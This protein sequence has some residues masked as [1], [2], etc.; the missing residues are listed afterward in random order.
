MFKKINFCTCLQILKLLQ[1]ELLLGIERYTVEKLK[2]KHKN[3]KKKM[4]KIVA[5][6][7]LIVFI[8]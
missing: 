1:N 7:K 6:L 2:L 8:C 5:V 4:K 3:I